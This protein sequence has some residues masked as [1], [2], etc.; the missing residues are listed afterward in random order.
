MV[1]PASDLGES[2]GRG[3]QNCFACARIDFRHLI[4]QTNDP[5]GSVSEKGDSHGSE[6]DSH[7]NR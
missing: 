1:R 2:T 4:A 7:S 3:R 5:D 6:Q